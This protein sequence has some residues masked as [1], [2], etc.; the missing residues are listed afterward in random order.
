MEIETEKNIFMIFHAGSQDGLWTN[1]GI[2]YYAV[3]T[4]LEGSYQAPAE[5]YINIF[6]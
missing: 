2:D 1:K 5:L 4:L 3:D 6:S